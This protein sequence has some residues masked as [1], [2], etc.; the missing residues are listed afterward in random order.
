MRKALLLAGAAAALSA[1]A[2]VSRLTARSTADLLVRGRAAALDE[3]DYELGR[4]AMASQISLLE[5]LLAS[6]PDDLRLR[7][8]T[9]ET[10]G[11]SAFLFLEP[12]APPRAK[13]LY[14]RGREQALAALALD[15]PRFK[16][17]AALPPEAFQTAL[18]AAKA[19][20]VPDLFW[21]GFCWAGEINLAKD[22]ASELADLPKA[23]ALMARVRE[24]DPA[25]HF[26]GADL[27]FGVYDASRPPLLGGN[28]K[29]AGEEFDRVRAATAGKYLMAL[30]LEAR[31]YAVAVQDRDLYERLLKT[32]LAAPSGQLP[33]ARLT[34]EA[35]KR[36]AAALLEKTDDYF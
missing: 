11:G 10:M 3:P 8:L 5:T 23:V 32:V 20:A 9:A 2:S 17:L 31:W 15:D 30:V 29:R 25:Y 6:D 22:D 28:P 12:A 26:H 7:R 21:A 27:F 35:A 19:E 16:G 1:C 34:D 13:A 33:E 14:R 24:L 4:E 36:R 18:K